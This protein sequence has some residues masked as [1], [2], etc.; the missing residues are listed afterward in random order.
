MLRYLCLFGIQLRTS[1]LLGMQYRLDFVLDALMTLFWTASSLVPLV[2]LFHQRSDIGGWSWPQALLVVG[3]FTVLRGVIEG[4]IQPA[5]QNVVELVR[6]GMLDF[7][8]LKPADSQFLVS[9]SR[10]EIWRGVDVLAGALILVWALVELEHVPT[11]LQALSS[12]ALL[13]GAVVI[14]YSIWIAVVALALRVVKV[15]NLTYFFSSVFEAARWPA[16]VYRGA[17]NFVFT[18]VIPLIVMT[19]YP[20]LAIVGE[21]EGRAIFFSLAGAL[22]FALAARLVWLRALRS[23]TSAGG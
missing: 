9:T 17:L 4:A 14:L 20:A 1:A 7:L 6:K 3:F 11:P 18:F 22:V 21:L 12:L 10:F 16:P 19:S 2:V 15:D 8:L 5:L 23:Y 13:C